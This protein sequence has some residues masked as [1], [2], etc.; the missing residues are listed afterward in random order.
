MTK[1]AQDIGYG[2]LGM[3]HTSA[4]CE[5]GG[6]SRTDTTSSLGA[7]PMHNTNNNNCTNH[8]QLAAAARAARD[9]QAE[10]EQQYEAVV[11]MKE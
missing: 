7:H 11:R 3:F 5:V 9:G 8:G 4:A 10:S 2:G 6:R 1:I